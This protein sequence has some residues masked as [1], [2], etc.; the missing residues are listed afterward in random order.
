MSLRPLIVVPMLCVLGFPSAPARALEGAAVL[1]QPAPAERY[2]PDFLGDDNDAFRR[3]LLGPSASERSLVPTQ[4][5]GAL[6]VVETGYLDEKGLDKLASDLQEATAGIPAFTGRPSKVQKRITVY[7]YSDGPM[8]LAHVPGAMPGEQGLMLRFVR[9]GAAPIF[10]EMTHML[11]GYSPSQSLAEGFADVVQSRFRPGQ[12]SAF[13]A[14]GTDPDAM[15][16][17]A[18]VVQGPAFFKT[19]GGFGNYTWQDPESR[20]DFYYCSWSF[21]RFLLKRAPL[22]KFWPVYDS[23]GGDEEY[24][25]SY[26][27]SREDL[28]AAWRKS[29]RAS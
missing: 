21:V 22:E 29:L 13:M 23:G 20:K 9:E 19:L 27:A 3:V 18:L 15:S 11:V 28:V 6:L 8:S 17:A 12:A 14:A 5:G 2:A 16:R 24:L 1:R 25:R 4:T 10:H 26:G 7:A